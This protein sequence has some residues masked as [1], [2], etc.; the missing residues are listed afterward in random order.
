MD[1]GECYLYC[2]LL[3]FVNSTC[4]VCVYEINLLIRIVCF[5]LRCLWFN[6]AIGRS[7]VQEVDR[8][9]CL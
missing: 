1:T 4:T 8:L 7:L 6:D 9:I 5:V 2:N 3:L